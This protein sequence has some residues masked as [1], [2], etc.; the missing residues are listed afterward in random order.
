MQIKTIEQHCKEG[1]LYTVKDATLALY[2]TTI[3]NA[4]KEK[5]DAHAY[6]FDLHAMRYLVIGERRARRRHS[7]R[8]WVNNPRS[9]PFKTKRAAL[10]VAQTYK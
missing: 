1:T 9:G 5:K 3:N 2:L 4:L 8:Y 6:D 7:V 10:R